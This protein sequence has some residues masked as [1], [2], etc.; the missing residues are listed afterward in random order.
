LDTQ[1]DSATERE[2]DTSALDGQGEGTSRGSRTGEEDTQGEESGQREETDRDFQEQ[3]T[4]SEAPSSSTSDYRPP[5]AANE[6][7]EWFIER[8][9][10]I[11]L[12]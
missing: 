2:G 5:P 1:Q 8:S 7:R 3:P 4:M 9:I 10:P 6:R 12:S 11:S